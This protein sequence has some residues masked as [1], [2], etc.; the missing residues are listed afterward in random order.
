MKTCSGEELDVEVGNDLLHSPELPFG[1]PLRIARSD[2]ED[3][4][5]PED[6]TAFGELLTNTFESAPAACPV[7]KRWATAY[8]EAQVLWAQSWVPR[9]AQEPS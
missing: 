4:M 8:I 5:T 1:S 7:E 3:L 9:V 2:I 6:C